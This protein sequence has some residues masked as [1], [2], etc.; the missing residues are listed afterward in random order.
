MC[1]R[2]TLHTSPAE[3]A[4]IFGLF[5]ESDWSP[6]YNIAPTQS[7]LVIRHAAHDAARETVQMRWGL[8]PSWSKS[9]TGPPLF[10]ARS[11]TV[12][13]KPSFRTAFRRRRCLI[14]ADG[15][16]E[17]QVI[18]PKQKQPHYITLRSGQP[19][20]FAGLWESWQPPDGSRIDSCTV[21]T[22]TANSL[23]QPL[24]DRM[25]VILS[26]DEF[27]PWLDPELTEPDHLW[28]M[29]DQYP[30][31]EMTAQPVSPLVGS[32]RNDSP[33]LIVAIR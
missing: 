32:V 23:M 15:F 7:V 26:P 1:G 22:T 6:R 31:N 20:A 8:V 24:H 2:Y 12:A 3:L 18:S 33:E 19:F 10:N 5:R 16:Y 9:L 13:E 28:P 25:P 30:A 27:A 21:L 29:I 17:W 14:P 11:E 4:E